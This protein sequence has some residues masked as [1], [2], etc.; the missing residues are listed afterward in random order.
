MT[1]LKEVTAP[2]VV[3][4][5][6]L[7]Y[8]YDRVGVF[9]PKEFPV[10]F[11]QLNPGDQVVLKKAPDNPH[12]HKAVSVVH[13][14]GNIGFL[15]RGRLQDMANDYLSVRRPIYAHIDSIDD[16]ERKITIFLAFYGS[17]L[18]VDSKSYKLTG[19]KSKAAQE[20]IELL[21]EDEYLIVSYDPDKDK[22][23]V[24]DGGEV[25]GYLPKSA[26]DLA[27]TMDCYVDSIDTDENDKYIVYVRFENPAP[28]KASAPPPPPV[29][30]PT[31][32]PE[33]VSAP[34]TAP[35]SFPPSPKPA[36]D[37]KPDPVI[38]RAE[39]ALAASSSASSHHPV[40]PHEQRA[41]DLVRTL[42]PDSKITFSHQMRGE[43]NYFGIHTLHNGQENRYIVQ[44]DVKADAIDCYDTRMNLLSTT[45]P[46]TPK[47][48]RRHPVLLLFAIAAI[49]LA[50]L[51]FFR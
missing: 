46:K 12:D 48:K 20:A 51:H 28:A 15:Y 35:K 19:G 6:R 16:A 17:T 31:P 4:G 1:Q 18:F 8:H 47:A 36:P 26:N 10:D 11:A 34:S 23:E 43:G 13:P 39:R 29:I 27:E 2:S 3:D 44:Y 30:K 42:Y 45:R 38:Q 32:K 40:S 21:T 41:V 37:P 5:Q 25:I 33:P 7:K 50:V 9:T 14:K 49:V 24:T 22:Y